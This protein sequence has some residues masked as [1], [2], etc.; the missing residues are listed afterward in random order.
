MY[1]AFKPA[2][3]ILASIVL[4]LGLGLYT[5]S[6]KQKAASNPNLSLLLRAS[7]KVQKE[8]RKEVATANKTKSCPAN[9]SLVASYNL[10]LAQQLKDLNHTADNLRS[11]AQ[12]SNESY[13]DFDNQLNAAFN[14]YNQR[15]AK[16]YAE[17]SAMLSPCQPSLPKPVSFD[18]FTP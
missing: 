5:P 2:G 10:A 16:I 17:Y 9:V 8:R 3:I 15:V 1:R 18:T 4:L 13:I 11:E 12:A 7:P 6:V 14:S